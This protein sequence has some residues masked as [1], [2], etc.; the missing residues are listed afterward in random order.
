LEAARCLLTSNASAILSYGSD[1]LLGKTR[2]DIYEDRSELVIGEATSTAFVISLLGGMNRS[3]VVDTVIDGYSSCFA[4]NK[5]PGVYRLF[6][7]SGKRFEILRDNIIDPF[8]QFL[9]AHQATAHTN[10]I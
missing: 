7:S 4:E 2:L 1:I 8:C 6:G 9:E 5:C 3:G 10:Y